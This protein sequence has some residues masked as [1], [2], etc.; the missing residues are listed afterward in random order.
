MKKCISGEQLLELDSSD[1][2]PLEIDGIVSI[3]SM[4]QYL[5]EDL[6]ISHPKDKWRVSLQFGEGIPKLNC[7]VTIPN[8]KGKSSLLPEEIKELLVNH[9][10]SFSWVGLKE[11]DIRVFNEVELCD[12]LWEMVKEVSKGQ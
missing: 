8:L 12:A 11:C 10:T 4:I 3:D 5:G 7:E 9:T 6:T 2:E 1:R